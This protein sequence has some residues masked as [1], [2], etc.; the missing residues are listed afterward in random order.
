MENLSSAVKNTDDFISRFNAMSK[1]QKQNINK[2]LVNLSAISENLNKITDSLSKSNLKKSIY[3]IEK[4]SYNFNQVLTE[5]QNGKGTISKLLYKDSLYQNLM[6]TSEAIEILLKD[7]KSNP[8]RY[9]HFS[10]FGRKE[11][12]N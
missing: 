3:N 6:N 8:K 2:T 1:N 12:T 4:L 11:K 9:V 7:L 5:I 10:L